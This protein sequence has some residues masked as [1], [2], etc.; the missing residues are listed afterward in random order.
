MLAEMN[1]NEAKSNNNKCNCFDFFVCL[2][3]VENSGIDMG[4]CFW[5][6]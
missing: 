1:Q 3:E 6:F 4:V 2:P 5:L